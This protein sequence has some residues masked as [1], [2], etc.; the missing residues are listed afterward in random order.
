MSNIYEIVGIAVN[1]YRKK[2]EITQAKLAE[3][4]NLSPN[5]IG[6]IERGTKKAS[7]ETIKKIADALQISTGKL[8]DGVLEGNLDESNRKKVLDYKMSK[9]IKNILKDK[10]VIYSIGKTIL[11]NINLQK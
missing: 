11:K 3:I 10:K 8:L 1:S 4:T 9:A 6:Q 7:L 2:L 5:F